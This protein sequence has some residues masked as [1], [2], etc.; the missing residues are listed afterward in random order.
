ML[1]GSSGDSPLGKSTI[2][3]LRK[4]LDQVQVSGQAVPFLRP[5][6][7]PYRYLGIL[8]APSGSLGE[9]GD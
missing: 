9:G 6:E 3:L 5:H 7:Q 1:Y 8:A 2:A 4:R